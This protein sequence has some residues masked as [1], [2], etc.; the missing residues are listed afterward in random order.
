MFLQLSVF[1]FT[2]GGCTH[3][4]IHTRPLQWTVRIL[5]ECIPVEILFIEFVFIHPEVFARKS[6]LPIVTE[7]LLFVS[8]TGSLT[9]LQIK[10]KNFIKICQTVDTIAQTILALLFVNFTL[11]K[12]NKIVFLSCSS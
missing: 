4:H 11:K 7:L 3:T 5:L 9:C 8:I 2:G 12:L 10:G 1:L 6:L